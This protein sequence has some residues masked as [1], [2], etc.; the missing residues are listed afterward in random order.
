MSTL[1][2]T[3]A[4]ILD[5]PAPS[6]ALY[7]LSG[8]YYTLTPGGQHLRVVREILIAE[9]EEFGASYVPPPSV[10]EKR[11]AQQKLPK[12]SLRDWTIT[13]GAAVPSERKTL[14]QLLSAGKIAVHR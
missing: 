10:F 7:D 3:I 6:R 11:V 14:M 9:K 5:V 8:D 4:S 12:I 13:I 2:K 1:P